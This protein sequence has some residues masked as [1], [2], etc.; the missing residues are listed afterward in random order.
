MDNLVSGDTSDK[1]PLMDKIPD[2]PAIQRATVA[3]KTVRNA[4][5]K[6]S[7]ICDLNALK[8]TF[9]NCDFSYSII[10]GGY[11]RDAVF[12]NCR[13]SGTKFFDCNFKS[14]N[15]YKCD[16]SFARFSTC[17]I[18]TAEIIASLPDQPNIRRE[19]LQNLKAN[20]VEAGDFASLGLLTLQE[21]EAAQRHYR[22]ALRG[23]DS[24]YR[25][26]YPNMLSKVRACANLVG[27][28]LGGL[29]W[30]HGER[31]WRLASSC[32]VILCFLALV[33]FW[34]LLPRVTWSETDK[35]LASLD[36]VFRLFLDL[37]PNP[38]F[39]GFTAVDFA[40]VAMR[41]IYIG[42]FISVLYKS[43]SHR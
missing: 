1:R 25:N 23:Y 21:I 4:S 2:M 29:I 6:A 30:G 28:W 9:E 43:I 36:Y 41:Y 18:D 34:S 14:A 39:A 8:T 33:N 27:L 38:T 19:S 37:N 26:K 24:Y 10:D 12:R 20:A 3:R 5:W 22:Y 35:G 11:F 40:I 16:F 17:L 31:P 15:F 7:E 13:F 32:F 42:L